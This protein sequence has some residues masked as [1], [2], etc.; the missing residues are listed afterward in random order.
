MF[1]V[2]DLVVYG[3]NGVF[4]VE[5]IGVPDMKYIDKDKLYYTL[6]SVY[7]N[8]NIYVPVDTN[9]SMRR[10]MTYDE[11]QELINQMPSVE[12]DICT[13]RQLNSIVEHYMNAIKS[14]DCLDLVQ[15]IK[16]IYTKGTMLG[17]IGKSLSQTDLSFMRKAEDLLYSELSISIGIPR[18]E[19]KDYIREKVENLGV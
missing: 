6:S 14:D 15:L 17:S 12:V 1:E 13:D 9:V 16:S 4:K 8:G 10:V 3:V 11:A 5:D 2:G 7:G 18:D 19:I